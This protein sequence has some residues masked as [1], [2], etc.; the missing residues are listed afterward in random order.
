MY[1][2]TLF[3]GYAEIVG[4]WVRA[5][6]A[7]DVPPAQSDPAPGQSANSSDLARTGAVSPLAR[8]SPDDRCSGWRCR[9]S[10]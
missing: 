4:Q 1:T 10:P 8:C 9:S 6:A 2:D 3:P 5:V 7:G